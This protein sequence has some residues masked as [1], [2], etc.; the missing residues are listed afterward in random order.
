MRWFS[1]IVL[2]ASW[3]PAIAAPVTAQ[4]RA[5]I[6]RWFV[7]LQQEN[8]TDQAAGQLAAAAKTDPY[9][10]QLLAKRLPPLIEKLRGPV[11]INAIRL[12]GDLRISEAVPALVELLKHLDTKGGPFT[13][14]QEFR[15]DDAPAGRALVEIGEPATKAVGQ[16]LEDPDQTIRWRAA[17]VLS[18]MNSAGADGEL[19]LHI[20]D[21]SDPGIKKYM[22]ANLI[23]HH[24]SRT[25]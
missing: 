9:A 12:A 22:Q 5:D 6:D 17:L 25:P 19:A 13:F 2:A 7:E 1:L 4:S 15:L 10:R 14:G 11:W 20:G 8:T 24:K 18:N 21:E 3:A 23:E 16:L